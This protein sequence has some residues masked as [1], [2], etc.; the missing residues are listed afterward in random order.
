MNGK[1][2][3]ENSIVNELKDSSRFFQRD[4]DT[5]PAVLSKEPSRNVVGHL[6]SL[7]GTQADTPLVSHSQ[8]PTD[9]AQNRNN[10]PKASNSE[11]SYM[12]ASVLAG[13]EA[14]LIECIRKRVKSVGKEITSLRLTPAEKSDLSELVYTLKRR[15]IRTSENEINRI[16]LNIMLA[17]FKAKGQS[18]LIARV[19]EALY[20]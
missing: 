4:T 18:S 6:E 14:E 2:L 5:P 20:E 7:R 17:D 8:T 3:D 12:P 10:L 11:Q 9:E 15:G 13:G 16:A 19:I 1:R